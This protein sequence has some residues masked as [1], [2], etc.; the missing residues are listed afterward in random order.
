MFVMMVVV[1]VVVVAAPLPGDDDGL[2]LMIMM[3]MMKPFIAWD[4]YEP[5]YKKILARGYKTFFVLNSTEH[6]IYPA[7]KC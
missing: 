2:I 3:M 7:H 1:V 6:E 5:C 4:T